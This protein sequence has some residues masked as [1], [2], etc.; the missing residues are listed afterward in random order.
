MQLTTRMAR[1]M[2]GGALTAALILAIAHGAEKG[3]SWYLKAALIIAL[4]CVAIGEF[5]SWHNAATAYHE[6]RLGSL[7]LW[8]LLGGVLTLGTLYTNFS[9]S[10]GNNTQKASVQKAA[11]VTQE[12]TGKTEAELTIENNKLLQKIQMAPLRGPEA[13]DAAIKR[14]K[15]DRYW[16]RTNGCTNTSGPQTRK[17][18][19]DYTSAIADLEYGKNIKVWESEQKVVAEKLTKVRA[20]R[21]NAPAVLAADQ[22][23]VDTLAWLTNIDMRSARQADAM[24]VPLL[25]QAMLLFGGILLANEHFRGKP[26]IPWVDFSKWVRRYHSAR[27]ALGLS[28]ASGKTIVIDETAA[29]RAADIAFS[30]Y[31]AAN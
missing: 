16:D 7:A 17:F 3:S 5:L 18:C 19:D 24:V 21:A 29:K 15:A 10:A 30:K 25:V 8:S 1:V 4:V 28:P 31:A 14:A 23:S 6:R 11:Y 27:Y 2:V 20:E 26:R 13:A 22:A 12:D 9:S